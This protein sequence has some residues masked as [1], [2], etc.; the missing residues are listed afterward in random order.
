VSLWLWLS[1]KFDASAFPNQEQVLQLSEK[2]IE[3]MEEGLLKLY[4]RPSTAVPTPVNK[5]RQTLDDISKVAQTPPLPLL[6]SH[7][8][9]LRL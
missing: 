2:L 5:P 4:D 8:F 9:V 3:Q 1:Q 6:L 7:L